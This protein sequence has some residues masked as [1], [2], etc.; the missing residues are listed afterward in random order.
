MACIHEDA[1]F[2]RRCRQRIERG[3]HGSAFDLVHVLKQRDDN[4]TRTPVMRQAAR[5]KNVQRTSSTYTANFA[6]GPH[7]SSA[8]GGWRRPG[9]SSFV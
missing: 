6:N 4:L 8:R 1:L 9:R 2:R 7:C 3:R 5:L